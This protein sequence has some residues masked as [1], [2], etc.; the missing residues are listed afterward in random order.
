MSCP[1]CK[2]T[3]NE[4]KCRKD[5]GRFYDVRCRWCHGSGKMN[6]PLVRKKVVKLAEDI[7]K[8]LP[9]PQIGEPIPWLVALT[10]AQLELV[11]TLHELSKLGVL[12]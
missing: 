3:G 10:N 12:R 1:L 2:G 8:I 5:T 4:K 9:P 6:V 7:E 11:K